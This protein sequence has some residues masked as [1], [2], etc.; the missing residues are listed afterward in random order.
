MEKTER[1][2]AEY[3]SSLSDDFRDDVHRLDEDFTDVMSGEGKTMWEGTFWGGGQQS[4]IG[5]GELVQPRP[6]RKTVE[7]FTIGL[8]AQQDY[9]SV[10]INAVEHGQ[11]I[12]ESFR[13]LL[14]NVTVGKSVVRF[15]SLRDVDL[16][17]L[18]DAVRRARALTH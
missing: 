16:P 10:Y 3:I 5:Y 4:I 7:W 2:P 18:L 17:A 11:Y 8:T 13:P 15:R 14:G 12:A 9:I 6:R 1:D